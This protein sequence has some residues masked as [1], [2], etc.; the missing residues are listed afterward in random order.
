MC[1]TQDIAQRPSRPRG[2][3]PGIDIDAASVRRARE[4]AGLS[5]AQLGGRDLTRQAVHLIETG[6]TRP[7]RRSLEVIAQRLC[8]PVEAFMASAEARA[9]ALDHSCQAHHY[10]TVLEL[11][12]GILGQPGIPVKLAASAHHYAGQAL[13][14]LG[15]LEE[16]VC[17]LR[18]AR[19]LFESINDPWRAVESMDWE[20]VALHDLGDLRALD[21]AEEALRRYRELPGRQP[22]TEARIL[23]HIGTFLSWR[24][25]F[26]RAETRYSDALRVVG[27]VR[28]LDGMARIYHGMA[29][30]R[31]AAGDM[32]GA[33]DGLQKAVALYSVEH[34]LRPAAGR[35]SLPK[36]ENDLG[37]L[38][39]SMGQLDRADEAL[40]SALTHISEAG[41]ERLRGLILLSLGELR[42]L[43]GRVGEAFVLVSQGMEL[44]QEVQDVVA[45]AEAHQQLGRLHAR[46]GR[47]D[48][49]EVSFARA[50][51]ILEKAGLEE[52]VAE[53]LRLY[54]R[55]R[56]DGRPAEGRQH[57]GA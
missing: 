31:Q 29:G 17:H 13:S 57:M 48:R 8:R 47:Y 51:E 22:E 12:Q 10:D 35:T 30:C 19:E 14:H 23:E 16:A 26:D 27:A 11:A 46:L 7:T 45:L 15:R 55:V 18:E 53:C 37:M 24:K 44:V 20:A 36:A 1:K 34:Q 33:L 3:R 9:A 38:L 32:R 50:L 28:D 54:E 25:V 41:D 49:V 21:L 5:Q 4:E 40:Q 2:R 43:Q 6:K 42:E 52:R 56:G 39:M